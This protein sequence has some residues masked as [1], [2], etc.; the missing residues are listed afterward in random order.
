MHIQRA[1]THVTQISLIAPLTHSVSFAIT[2]IIRVFLI[3][4]RPYG[5]LKV[6]NCLLILSEVEIH[7]AS[8][9]QKIFCAENVFLVITEGLY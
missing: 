8:V 9:E 2:S 5:G 4:L 1:E 7:N 6:Y 3:R